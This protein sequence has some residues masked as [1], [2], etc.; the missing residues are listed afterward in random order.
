MVLVVLDVGDYV[1]VRIY[2]IYYDLGVI[3]DGVFFMFF[4]F[5]LYEI[6]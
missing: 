4:G 2:N 3:I 1:I 6:D 5:L